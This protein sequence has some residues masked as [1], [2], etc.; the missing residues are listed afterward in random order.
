MNPLRTLIVGFLAFS[1]IAT[2]ADAQQEAAKRRVPAEILKQFDANQDG[3]LDKQERR[4]AHEAIQKRRDL[5]GDLAKQTPQQNRSGRA[6]AAPEGNPAPQTRRGL[7][8]HRGE[9]VEAT[10]NARQQAPSRRSLKANSDGTGNSFSPQTRRSVRPNGPA[11]T[12]R[13]PRA[14]SGKHI[15]TANCDCACHNKAG[16][17]ASSADQKVKRTSKK[18][19]KTG[20]NIKTGKKAAKTGKNIKAGKKA[21]KTG[22]KAKSC[23]KA[24]K[25][26]QGNR[27]SLR[28]S[29]RG[30]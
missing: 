9:Q 5:R 2:S 22:K 16:K 30:K 11:E 28:K 15:H 25:A 1:A 10:P 20:K 21:A 7:R 8:A 26:P 18:A 27:K 17:K 13:A 6:Q 12:N 29:S 24:A 3:A 4:A 23:K 14:K 19:A